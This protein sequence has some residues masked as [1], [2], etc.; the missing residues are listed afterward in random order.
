MLLMLLLMNEY[1]ESKPTS[2]EEDPSSQRV[3]RL[4]LG[5]CRLMM[6]VDVCGP[7]AW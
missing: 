4:R 5:V 3:I 7:F 1:S 2:V 6:V